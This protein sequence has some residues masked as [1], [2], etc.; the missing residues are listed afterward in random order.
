MHAYQPI[1]LRI[2]PD[3][4]LTR[5]WTLRDVLARAQQHAPAPETLVALTSLVEAAGYG[6]ATPTAAELATIHRVARATL[7]DLDDKHAPREPGPE[8]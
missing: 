8:R 7:A 6:P 4:R 5:T 3:P 2:V 1:A